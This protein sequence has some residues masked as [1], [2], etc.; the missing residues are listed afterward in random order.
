MDKYFKIGKIVATHGVAGKMVLQ[1]S[2]GKATDL[3]KTEVLFVEDAKDSFLPY[4]IKKATAKSEEDTYIEVE[5]IESKEA[6]KVL[7]RKEIW[8]SEKDF[9]AQHSSSAP[10]SMLGFE[11]FDG[12]QSL[13]EILE[14]V[15]QKH[16]TLCM[17]LLGKKEAWL[18]VHEASLKK[19]DRKKKQVFLELP[20]GLLDV[21]R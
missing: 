20:D 1:H 17:V 13:G 21:Y 16:Q 4:F 3:K 12:D 5:G 9:S 18:P 2:L 11:V 7:L 15:E 8:L 6:A 14:V 10:I 19:I